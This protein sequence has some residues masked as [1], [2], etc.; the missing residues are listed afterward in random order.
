MNVP[1]SDI[2]PK[3]QTVSETLEETRNVRAKKSVAKPLE[4]ETVARS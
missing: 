4:K 3:T 1:D 2:T